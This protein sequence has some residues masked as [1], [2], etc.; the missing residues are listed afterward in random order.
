MRTLPIVVAMLVAPLALG[1]ALPDSPYLHSL[2]L[3]LAAN[4]PNGNVDPNCP[5]NVIAQRQQQQRAQQE[6]A[7]QRMQQE[8]Q[9][10]AQLAAQQRAQQEAQQKAQ[11]AA[12]MKAQQEAQQKQ[13]QLAQQKAQQEAQLRQ[14]Q[15]MQQKQQQSGQQKQQLGQQQKTGQSNA[16]QQQHEAQLRAQQQAQQKQQLGQQQTG[17]ASAQQQQQ[18]AQLRA[19]QQA[20]QKQQLGQQQAGQASAQQQQHDARLRAQQ[21]AMQKGAP[22]GGQQIPG[23][24]NAAGLAGARQTN[25]LQSQQALSGR[26]QTQSQEASAFA[27][28]RRQVAGSAA[29]PATATAA[30]PIAVN[31]ATTVV[32][33]PNRTGYTVDRRNPDGSRIVMSQ[34]VRPNGQHGVVAYKQVDDRRTGAST[35]IYMDGHRTT[36]APTY[37]SRTIYRGP[38]YVTYNNG[39]RAAYLP[40][41]RPIYREHLAYVTEGGYSRQVVNRTVYTTV[42]QGRIVPLAS[43]IVRVYDVVPAYGVPV[44]VYRPAY[45]GYAYYAPYYAPFGVPVAV[46]PACVICPAQVALFEQPVQSYSDP[47]DLMGDLQ[48]AGA[49]SDGI[50]SALDATPNDPSAGPSLQSGQS[51]VEL[52]ELRNEV[53]EVQQQVSVTAS[54]NAELNAALP[55]ASLQKASLNVQNPGAADPAKP[56]AGTQVRIPEYARQQMRKQVRLSI[57]Q[58]QNQ[59]PLLVSNIMAAEYAKIYI[60]QASTP[61]DVFDVNT[62]EQCTLSGGGMISVAQAPAGD[63]EVAQMKVVAA[64]PGDCRADQVVEVSL[65]DL[66][67]MLNAFSERVENNMKDLNLCSST[68]NACARS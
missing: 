27:A 39:L 15:A 49:L 26:T 36:V 60:F 1:Q 53:E 59:H 54:D 3:Q 8:A 29:H 28:Q 25:V 64:R 43:P 68:P 12:Q 48:I 13:Q 58:H 23:Q 6:A 18:E 22:Q 32:P 45:Y 63:V 52:A 40:G 65:V 5:N 61:I 47:I 57:A 44:Y 56:G 16:Q 66:Q 33:H 20:Q 50:A 14:Q 21:E 38:S 67:D 17:Q 46:G 55:P 9:Q 35:R 30:K 37:V 11:Q 41:G 31:A 19:R 62:G 42:Y 2:Y 4:C 7:Q 24:S 51:D 10:R 34:T